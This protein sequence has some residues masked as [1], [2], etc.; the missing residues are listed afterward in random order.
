[1]MKWLVFILSAF[2]ST[3]APAAEFLSA[4]EDIPLMDGLREEEAMS[5]DT[6]DV[7]IIEQFVSSSEVSAREFISFYARA[8][9]SL[10]WKRVASTETWISFRREDESL[11]IKV[12]SSDPL[13]ASFNLKPWGK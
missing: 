1:M 4:F 11:S 13:V 9:P 10:G 7:R 8:M 2:F 6:D 5:F 12:E 3:A